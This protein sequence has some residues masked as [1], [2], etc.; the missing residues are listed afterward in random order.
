MLDGW[1]DGSWDR[2]NKWSKYIKIN[3]NLINLKR[4]S[5]FVEIYVSAASNLEKNTEMVLL[6][7]TESWHI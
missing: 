3:N 4:N 6:Y 2:R 5:L 7:N 1:G